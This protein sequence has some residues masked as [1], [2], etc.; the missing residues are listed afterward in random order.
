[1]IPS[2][3]ATSNKT[4]IT[5]DNLTTNQEREIADIS[6]FLD[7]ESILEFAASV[8]HLKTSW[9]RAEDVSG[10]CVSG[11]ECVEV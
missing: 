5:L 9:S 2:W 8:L 11:S 10:S 7:Q 1:M 6:F 3:L 4:R